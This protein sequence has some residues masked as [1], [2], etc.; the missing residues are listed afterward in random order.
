M[1]YDEDLANRIRELLADQDAVTEKRMFGGLAFLLHGNM[2]VAA[3]RRGGV[4]VRTDPGESADL[5]AASGVER[6]VM[7][8]REMENWLYVD[9]NQ[10][11]TRRDLA[12][13]V[14]RGAAFA[15]TLSPK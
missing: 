15:A 11:R 1:A 2:A 13:W 3:S 5:V 6:M 14:E 7:G 10:V 12:A 4:L 9:P 8:G